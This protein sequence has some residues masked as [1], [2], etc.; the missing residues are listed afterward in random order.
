MTRI[1]PSRFILAAALVVG[2]LGTPVG[3]GG[4]VETP[5]GP[6]G[7][8]IVRAAT[9]D[10]TI[11]SSARYDVQPTRHRVHVTVEL[12]LMN[13]LKDTV[14]KRYYF[15][16]AFLAVLPGSSAFGLSWGGAGQPSVRVATRTK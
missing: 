1:R 11:V 9:P 16:H 7:V 13:R 14:T 4:P 6:V 2:V 12:T 5:V 3:S 8:P 10:L 15:D